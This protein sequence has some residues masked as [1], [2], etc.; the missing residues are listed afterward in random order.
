[1]EEDAAR[2]ELRR[3]TARM[4]VVY[5][6]LDSRPRAR[7]ILADDL[8][9]LLWVIM[10]CDTG[11]KAFIMPTGSAALGAFPQPPHQ[12]AEMQNDFPRRPDD[13]R[14]L[15]PG[16]QRYQVAFFHLYTGSD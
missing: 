11:Q 10:H 16:P 1:M 5:E 7:L 12:F 6:K 9:T 15:T 14:T 4:L 3:L 2:K 8:A 13:G